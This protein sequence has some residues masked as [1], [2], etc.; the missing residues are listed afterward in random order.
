MF[1]D[2]SASG[3]EWKRITVRDAVKEGYIARPLDGNHGEKHPKG[4]DYVPTGVPFIMA[5]QLG[6]LEE[7]RTVRLFKV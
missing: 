1:G 5:A 3:D 6:P 4:E 7:G 2:A